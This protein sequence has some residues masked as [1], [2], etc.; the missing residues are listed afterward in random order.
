MSEIIYIYE[1]SDP[2]TGVT[3]YVGKTVD[4]ERRYIQHKTRKESNRKSSWVQSLKRVGLNPVM[5][6]LDEVPASEWEFWEMWYIELFKQWGC[7]LVNTSNG[8]DFHPEGNPRRVVRVDVESGDERYFDSLTEGADSI[9]VKI[10]SVC[11]ACG[12]KSLTLGGYVWF[13]LD[14][15]LSDNHRESKVRRVSDN[16][17]GSRPKLCKRIRGTFPDGSI[18]DFDS[19]K[20]AAGELG[21]LHTGII[22][23]LRGRVKTSMKIRWEYV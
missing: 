5:V 13:Y 19:I 2:R 15:Y 1:L 3:R 20:S 14:D 23:A 16:K 7:E 11:G 8:G 22:N 9:G 10:S 12:G 4:P 17:G 21:V 18:R 6:I